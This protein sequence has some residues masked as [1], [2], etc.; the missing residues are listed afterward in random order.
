MGNTEIMIGIIVVLGV[1]AG[2]FYN[3]Q[4]NISVLKRIWKYIGGSI[5]TICLFITVLL[6][7]QIFESCNDEVREKPVAFYRVNDH[8]ADPQNVRWTVKA[9]EGW[10][11]DV[12]A[13]QVKATSK[14]RESIYSGVENATKD[15]FDIVGRLVNNGT[16]VREPLTGAIL[17]R[18]AR[19]SLRVYG[20]Y[21]EIRRPKN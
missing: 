6:A 11:I 10:E 2:V 16:C 3:L 14:S 18:D 21:T 9:E 19:G 20:K 5:A 12:N 1:L 4:K 17:I 7:I 15:G 8:C 13:I